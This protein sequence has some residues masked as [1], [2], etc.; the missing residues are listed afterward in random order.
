MVRKF[1]SLSWL[2]SVLSLV[3]Y[4][5]A[6]AQTPS[7]TQTQSPT[8]QT[9]PQ[10]APAPSPNVRGTGSNDDLSYRIGPG[11]ELDIRVFGRA[12]LSRTVRVDN[13]GKSGCRCSRKCR[14]PVTP[15]PS[16]PARSPRN[17][18][19]FYAIRRLMFW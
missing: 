8:Q 3:L 5:I 9:P 4:P 14:P 16:S 18:K 13:Y 15:K 11:D 1:V 12:E 19:N 17:T 10:I 7:S 2:L 6:E